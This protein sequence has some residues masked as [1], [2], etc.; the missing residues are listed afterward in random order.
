MLDEI[1]NMSDGMQSKLLRVLEDRNIRRVGGQNM[2][3]VNV[4]IIS[5]TNQDLETLCKEGK[6]RQ[7]LFF[8]L[9]IL[10]ISLPPLRERVE[11]IPT[12]VKHFIEKIN[13]EMFETKKSSERKKIS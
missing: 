3:P 11:D 13:Q 9:N 4:R 10:N 1:E 2:I 7:D 8:R 6:F 12:L 5:A